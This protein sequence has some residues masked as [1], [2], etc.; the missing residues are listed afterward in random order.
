MAFRIEKLTVKAQ[1]A[2]GR[3]RQK[4]A[5]QGNAQIEPLHLLDGLL[6]EHEG[7]VAAILD[8]IGADRAQL[9]QIVKAE[10]QHLPRVSGGSAPNPSPEMMTVL[11]ASQE[12]ATQMK[13]DFV[14][15]EHLFLALAAIDTKAQKLL[16]L[17][18][19]SPRMRRASARWVVRG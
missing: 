3:G 16:S 11:E 12:S 14:S 15:T 17:N 19:I 9:V 18:A 13:D 8:K 4:A 6:A 7:I 2:V 5:E 1:E 10:L